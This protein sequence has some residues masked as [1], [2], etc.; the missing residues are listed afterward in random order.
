MVLDD[1]EELP[2]YPS[3]TLYTTWDLSFTQI[4]QQNA[5]AAK[6]LTF[7]A[8]F[9]RQDIWY[10]LLHAAQGADRPPWFLE[11]ISDKFLF[12]SAMRTLTRY[13]LVE[14]H[15]RTGSYSLHVCVHDWTLNSLNRDIDSSQYWL[16]FDCVASH[17]RFEDWENLSALSYRRLTPHAVRLAHERFQQAGAQQEWLQNELT[18]AEV[19]GQLLYRQIQYKAAERMCLRVL[20][21]REEAWGPE[22]TS[23]LD[24]VNNLGILYADQGKMAEAEEMYVRALRGQEKA[25]G[26]EHTSTLSTVNNLGILYADQGKMAEAE[27]MYVRALRGYEK[28]W[29]P[30]HTSTLD[31][32]NNLGVLYADQGK[33]AEAEEMYVRALRGY[34]KA[35]GKDR[36]RAQIIARNLQGLHARK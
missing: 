32:V 4:K 21:R 28:A 29:G 24:T 26:P 23:T 15:H 11:L 9:D 16:A 36:A 19:I 20:S 12:E 27:E 18:G 13:C 7:L 31:T 10:S 22:H 3:R 30:E 6:L 1:K 14:A 34:E 2:D 35:V 33:M 8:Y 25:W 17:V 5:R